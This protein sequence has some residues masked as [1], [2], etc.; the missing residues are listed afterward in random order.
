MKWSVYLMFNENGKCSTII[1]KANTI[2]KNI[3][4]LDLELE[5]VQTFKS[6]LNLNTQ[7]CDPHSQT[8]IFF[9]V[10]NQLRLDHLIEEKVNIITQLYLDSQDVYSS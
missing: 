7:N 6:I 2:A 9:E 5:P 3:D 8:N 4:F 10:K 1:I